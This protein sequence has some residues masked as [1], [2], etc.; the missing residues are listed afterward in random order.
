MPEAGDELTDRLLLLR[1]QG[2]HGIQQVVG[3]GAHLFVL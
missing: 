3:S 1:G 2:L